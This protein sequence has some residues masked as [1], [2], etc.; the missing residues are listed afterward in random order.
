[1]L[2]SFAQR[3]TELSLF[4]L[5]FGSMV[6]QMMQVGEVAAASLRLFGGPVLSQKMLMGGL[7]ALLVLPWCFVKEMKQ[8]RRACEVL[9][10]Y[11]W[12]LTDACE[13]GWCTCCW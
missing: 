7:V 3:I 13:L 2:P 11:C 4:V 9:I 8:V 5:L 6:G 12:C 10:S 1:M